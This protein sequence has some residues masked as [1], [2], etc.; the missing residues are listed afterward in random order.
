M[1]KVKLAEQFSD[2]DSSDVDTSKKSRHV[3]TKKVYD[4]NDEDDN[5]CPNIVR[6]TSSKKAS[7]ENIVLKLKM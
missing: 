4:E 6:V 1:S 2:I 3:R 5:D 7:F